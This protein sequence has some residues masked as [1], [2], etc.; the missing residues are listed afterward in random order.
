MASCKQAPGHSVLDHGR[1]VEK[2]LKD[3]YRYAKGDGGLGDFEPSLWRLPD[4]FK[5]GARK[6]APLLLPWE[7]LSTYAIYHDCAKPYCLKVDEDGKRH[8]PDHAA[9]SKELWLRID[10]NEQVARLMGMDMD[11][12]RLK[13][14]DLPE[15]SKRLEAASLLFTGLAE[16]HANSEMFGGIDSESFKIKWRQ[17]DRR[18]RALTKL[19]LDEAGSAPAKEQNASA[20]QIGSQPIN[21]T[22]SE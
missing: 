5:E 17:I 16:I 7:V 22:V 1:L 9:R 3:L 15:F 20:A 10:G 4:W 8:F 11:I 14:Q 19:L 18:G 21:Q 13:A 12:H 2:K 6:L